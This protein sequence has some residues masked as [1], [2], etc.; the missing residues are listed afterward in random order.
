MRQYIT[1][2]RFRDLMGTKYAK[3]AYLAYLTDYAVVID[4]NTIIRAHVRWRKGNPVVTVK[5]DGS[6]TT[7]QVTGRFFDP[8]K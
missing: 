4:G 7:W 3:A 8:E 6:N 5:A 2:H 1:F